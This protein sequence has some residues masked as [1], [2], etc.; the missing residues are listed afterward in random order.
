M[1]RR[2][3]L[4]PGGSEIHGATNFGDGI[5]SVS[6]QTSSSA[7]RRKCIGDFA[8]GMKGGTLEVHNSCSAGWIFPKC[9]GYVKFMVLYYP[10]KLQI[11]RIAIDKVIKELR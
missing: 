9:A 2:A 11:N 10:T 3:D 8:I 6:C 5:S 4:P 7:R 1:F